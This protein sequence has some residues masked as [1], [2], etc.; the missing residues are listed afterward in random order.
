MMCQ[1]LPSVLYAFLGKVEKQTLFTNEHFP[2][3]TGEN[4]S[5]GYELWKGECIYNGVDRDE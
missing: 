3:K 5:G 2:G 1:E 4:G